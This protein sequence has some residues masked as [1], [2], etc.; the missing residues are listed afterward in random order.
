VPKQS[1]YFKKFHGGW[2]GAKGREVKL[3]QINSKYL[4]ISQNV[5]EEGT[6][7]LMHQ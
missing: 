6:K 5:L 2:L 1:I 4:K 3:T 7:P